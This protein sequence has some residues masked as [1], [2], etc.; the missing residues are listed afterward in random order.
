LIFEEATTETLDRLLLEDDEQ[1]TW[2]GA[3]V[4]CAVT[5]N[6][7]RREGRVDEEGEGEAR[8]RLDRLAGEWVEVRPMDDVRLLA[9]LVSKYHPLKAADALQLAAALRWC[10]GDTAAAGF[11]CLDE[12]LRRAAEDEGFNV[13]PAAEDAA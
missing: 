6:R 1:A 9:V 7:L 3:W 12:R 5:V 11:V 2:W 13:L 8:A 4:E 10:E